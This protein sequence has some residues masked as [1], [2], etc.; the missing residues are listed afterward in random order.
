MGA[1]EKDGCWE[2][3]ASGVKFVAALASS[4]NY[5]AP[6]HVDSDFVMS[7]HQLNVDNVVLLHLI[8]EL[9]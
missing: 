2:T 3:V 4:I 6:A 8:R 5:S 7:I 9:R 1:A